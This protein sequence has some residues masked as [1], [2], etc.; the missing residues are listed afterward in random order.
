MNAASGPEKKADGLRDIERLTDARE[1]RDGA[2][3][4][5]VCRRFA[6]SSLDRGRFR[7]H[8]HSA[9]ASGVRGQIGESDCL[10]PDP[11]YT[12]RP[13][14]PRAIICR[15][16]NWVRKKQPYKLVEITRSRS[17][18]VSSTS[19]FEACAPA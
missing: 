6:A 7:Q 16:V 9:F 12:I 5:G 4:F 3:S 15:A 11:M 19:G 17:A 8:F 1:R 14:A 2:P 10:H 13:E 18:S